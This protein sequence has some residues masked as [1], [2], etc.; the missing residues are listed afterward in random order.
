MRA[1]ARAV[2]PEMQKV[3]RFRMLKGRFFNEGDTATSLPVVVVNREF[4]R[5]T[6]ARTAI[7]QSF[8]DAAA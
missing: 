5:S 7:R 6:K 3:F 4:V 8:W 1:Q 2:T